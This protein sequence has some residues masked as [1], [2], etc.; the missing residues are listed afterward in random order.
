MPTDEHG[1]P[2]E[3]Y[4]DEYG[5]HYLTYAEMQKAKD[6]ER[7]ISAGEYNP[8]VGL[9]DEEIANLRRTSLI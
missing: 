8:G 1:A 6:E 4:Y 3:C 7:R 9:T 2:L 5:S